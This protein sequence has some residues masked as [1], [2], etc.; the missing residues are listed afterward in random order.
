MLLNFVKVIGKAYSN[1]VPEGSGV[2]VQVFR[3]DPCHVG[4]RPSGH[5]ALLTWQ[6]GKN[7][8]FRTVESVNSGIISK[9]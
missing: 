5:L 4:Q 8:G 3:M 2:G 6:A 1:T 9:N 7:L